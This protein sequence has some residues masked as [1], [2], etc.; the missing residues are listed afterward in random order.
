MQM[1]DRPGEVTGPSILHVADCA[2]DVIGPYDV[3]RDATMM[4]LANSANSTVDALDWRIPLITYLRDPNV[5]TDRSIWWTTFNYVLIG[6][7]FYRQTLSD[8]ML[9]CL[10]LDD[11]ILAIS[12]VYEGICSIH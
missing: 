10:G 5:R 4:A 7:E 3:D 8:I 9:K 2:S 1:L 12:E 6:D 11:A